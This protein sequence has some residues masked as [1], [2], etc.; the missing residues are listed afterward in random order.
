MFLEVANL[1]LFCYIFT[2]RRCIF[3]PKNRQEGGH[4]EENHSI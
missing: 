2:L 1:S 3:M 4:N